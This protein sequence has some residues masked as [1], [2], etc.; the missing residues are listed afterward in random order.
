MGGRLGWLAVVKHLVCACAGLP[1]KD[2]PI[3]F[4]FEHAT[5]ESVFQKLAATEPTTGVG[6]TF[7]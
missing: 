6:E 1:R 3:L 5:P 2:A 7:Q 4:E